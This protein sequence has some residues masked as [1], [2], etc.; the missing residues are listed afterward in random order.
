MKLDRLFRLGKQGYNMYRSY[1]GKSPRHGS[2]G[3][4]GYSS[5]HRSGGTLER[6]LRRFLK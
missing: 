1:K 3:G 6:L 5:R 2:Y 4:S